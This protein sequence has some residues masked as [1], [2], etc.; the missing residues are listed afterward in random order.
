MTPTQQKA[1]TLALNILDVSFFECPKH[2]Y[3]YFLG[4][5]DWAL[6]MA[7][8]NINAVGTQ[9][10]VV[11]VEVLRRAVAREGFFAGMTDF[12]APRH[13]CSFL[14]EQNRT[15]ERAIPLKQC[16][17][18][19]ATCPYAT[20]EAIRDSAPTRHRRKAEDAAR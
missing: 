13:F 12:K 7:A 8:A 1:I 19:Q 9:P 10:P 16:D 6:L 17:E 14:R 11:A 2:Y 15:G 18:G 3:Q 20:F 4:N 5:D